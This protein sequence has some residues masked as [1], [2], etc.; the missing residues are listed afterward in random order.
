MNNKKYTVSGTN[1]EDVKR[2]NEQSGLTYNE[3][4]R[5]LANKFNSNKK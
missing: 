1:I 4:K 3:A 5:V 2:Q